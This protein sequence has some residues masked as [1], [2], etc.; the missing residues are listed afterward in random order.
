MFPFR[1]I[2]AVA[3]LLIRAIDADIPTHPK[4]AAKSWRRGD[5]VLVAPDGHSWGRNELSNADNSR[6]LFV[7]KI[8]DVTVAQCQKYLG[9][10]WDDFF[11]TQQARRRFRLVIDEI[12]ASVR[13]TIRNQGWVSFNWS[14][15][16][17]WVED[18]LTQQRET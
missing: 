8:P 17:G 11:T 4:H 7:L 15:I 6:A 12:P 18:K 13:T 3:E 16:K 5:V 10:W 1:G 9:E 14:Q 2:R